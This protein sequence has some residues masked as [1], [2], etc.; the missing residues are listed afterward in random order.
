MPNRVFTTT[1]DGR[2]MSRV[3][4][5]GRGAWL[6]HG[7]PPGTTATSAPVAVRDLYAYVAGADGQVHRLAWDGDAWIWQSSPL[8]GGRRLSADGSLWGTWADYMPVG[9]DLVQS[10]TYSMLWAVTAD[11]R[12]F[13]LNRAGG[14][15]DHGN[16]G[17]PLA[18]Q[19]GAVDPWQLLIRARDGRLF[20]YDRNSGSWVW[21]NLG[22]SSATG[23]PFALG[24]FRGVVREDRAVYLSHTLFTAWLK[25]RDGVSAAL[26]AVPNGVVYATTTGQVICLRLSANGLAFETW[27]N[28]PPGLAGGQPLRATVLTDHTTVAAGVAGRY[29]EGRSGAGWTDLGPPLPAGAGAPTAVPPRN[30]RWRARLGYMSSLVVAHVDAAAGGDRVHPRLGSDLGF[31]AE[32][33][34]GWALRDP[35]PG[36][37]G[38]GTQGIGIAL[39]DVRGRGGDAPRRDLVTLWVQ[40][41]GNGGNYPRWRV[42]W[43]VDAT[44]TPASWSAVKQSPTPVATT[45]TSGG[46]LTARTW[47]RDCD[48]DVA[49]LDGD[50]RPELV[51]AYVTADNPPRAF[52]RVGWGVDANG[53]TTQGWSESRPLPAAGG[54]VVGIGVAVLDTTSQFR[55]DLVVLYVTQ[56]GAGLQA[57][58]RIGSGIN[59]RGTVTGGWSA[60][61]PVG[62]GPL[63]AAI[64]GASLTAADFSGS[65]MPDLVVLL[66][67][68]GPTDN[69]GRYRVGWD[70]SPGTGQPRRWSGDQQVPG[71][72]GWENRGAGVAVGDVDPALVTRKKAFA[73]AFT[74]AATAHQ[75]V[76]AAAQRLSVA[77]DAE[78]PLAPLAGDTRAALEPGPRVERRTDDVVTGVDLLS[79]R[80]SDRLNPVLAAPSFPLPACELVR[81]ISRDY[82]LPGADGV[83]PDTVSLLRG[84]PAFVEAFM[85]GLNHEMA[86][87]LLWRELP[88][89]RTATFFR[90]FWDRTSGA[91][92]LPP[93]G[94]WNAAAALGESAT[95]MGGP[96]MAVLVVRG[97]LLRR[98]PNTV[99]SAI[100]ATLGA[101]GR[102]H[103][104]DLTRQ[105]DFRGTMPPDLTFFGF[106]F[107]VAEARGMGGDPGWFFAF[108]EHP[109]EPRFGLDEPGATPHYGEPPAA[110]DDLDW[111]RI[112]QD[113]GTLGRL[114][115]V[116]AELPFSRSTELPLR[117][118]T[119]GSERYRWG[120]NA[121]HTAHITLQRPVLFAIH[122][123]DLLAHTSGDWHVTHVVRGRHRSILALAG[124][125]PDGR[126]WR[127]GRSEAIAALRAR[128]RLYVQLPGGVRAEVVA[129]RGRG[130]TEYLRTRAGGG[131]GNNLTA[132]PDLPP[133]VVVADA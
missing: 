74:D 98:H 26:G 83:P 79:V 45:I 71:W 95:G 57:S 7:T 86:R 42:G 106:P 76:L 58:Y 132:L 124:Q 9:D 59:A 33:R 38:T 10:G 32:V 113:E 123:T 120:E 105:P 19:P 75:R 34:G 52:Y 102:R 31:D 69:V 82:L 110:W 15:V 22:G 93:I 43:D 111:A 131:L 73:T 55:P 3:A 101:D 103:L 84:T 25:V 104:G 100:H 96:D 64:Q 99:V 29:L 90:T 92:D 30:R 107:T 11:G 70:V 46:A 5:A 60:P 36:T 37:T 53:D 68:N 88:A 41:A 115:H 63:P 116:P 16:P 129:V 1:T 6:D 40:Q 91:P 8:P 85:V 119:T 20:V 51:L 80:S 72:W 108:A 61:F 17:T 18:G 23:Q 87:E 56:T 44:G 94:T 47:V 28:P 118:D 67:E 12:L 50:G 89:D 13:Q 14:W 126:W 109:T 128:E 2:V 127:L 65:E 121:A 39:A 21:R 81:D 54:T 125:H 77:A 24:D 133:G 122:A 49:D 62:G 112:A 114:G 130:G 117:D 66:V 78:V 4:Q 35:M 48:V 97:E 27:L